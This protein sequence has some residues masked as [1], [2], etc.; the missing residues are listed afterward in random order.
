MSTSTHGRI[1][2]LGKAFQTQIKVRFGDV[3][4]A[5]IAYFPR[6]VGYFHFAFEDFWENYIGTPYHEVINKEKLGFPS[7]HLE[8]DFIKP[9]NFGELLTAEVSCLR[10]GKSSV[11]F[12]YVLKRGKTACVSAV[13][14]HVAVDMRNFKPRA[15]PAKYRKKFDPGSVASRFV[16]KK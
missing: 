9:L 15:I 1:P 14:T 13:I 10:M 12:R 6:I 3:D 4:R 11:D 2:P 8:V 7:V 5:G 16:T